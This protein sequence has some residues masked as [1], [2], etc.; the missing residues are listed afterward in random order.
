MKT[1]ISVLLLSMVFLVGCVYNVGLVQTTA[2]LLTVSNVS[3]DTAMK[4]AADLYS[5]GR[6]TIG[7]KAEIVKI[8][9]TFAK[10][11]NAAVEALFCYQETKDLAEQEKMSAQIAIASRALS[12]LLNLIKPYLEVE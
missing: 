4:T 9:R 6:I 12:E 3:Y 10:A 7:E 5:Q 2:K 1:R 8:G 11:H